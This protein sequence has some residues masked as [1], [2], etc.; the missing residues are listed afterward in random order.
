MAEAQAITAIRGDQLQPGRRED[1]TLIND[2]AQQGIAYVQFFPLAGFG[3]L[4]L[5]TR[6]AVS[7]RLR[8]KSMQVALAWLL[9]RS[10]NI[11]L[12]PGTSSVPSAST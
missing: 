3:L 4:R 12:I 11:L 1:D 2:L 10:A 6:S 9:H 7:H 8:S 5:P